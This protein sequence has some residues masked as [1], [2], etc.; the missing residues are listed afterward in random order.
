MCKL[1]TSDSISEYVNTPKT[2]TNH[3]L[4][5]LNTENDQGLGKAIMSLYKFVCNKYL[6][7]P[8]K[9]V[10]AYILGEP[11][12]QLGKDSNTASTHAL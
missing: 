2:Q 6:T 8:R 4:V 12:Y 5:S 10:C 9:E 7:I 1:M 11:D 3:V